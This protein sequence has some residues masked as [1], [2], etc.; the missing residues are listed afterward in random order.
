VTTRVGLGQVERTDRLVWTCA[1]HLI[2][3]LHSKLRMLDVVESHWPELEGMM[4]ELSGAAEAVTGMRPPAPR[5]LCL[6]S[7][8]APPEAG[9]S[10]RVLTRAGAAVAGVKPSATVAERFKKY[11][12]SIAEQTTTGAR[13]A[14]PPCP[15]G[16]APWRVEGTG[17][18]RPPRS[19]CLL[20]ALSPRGARPDRDEGPPVPKRALLLPLPARDRGRCAPT[21]GP[22]S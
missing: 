11:T 4:Q 10:R 1:V 21:G 5:P 14:H 12:L 7:P 19:R 16:L 9:R 2:G 22:F 6:P 18:Y 17:C 3:K 15:A 13:R 20:P 8:R